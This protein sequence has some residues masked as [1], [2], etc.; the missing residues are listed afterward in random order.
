MASCCADLG[1]EVRIHLLHGV[2]EKH[3]TDL[4]THRLCVSK[5]SFVR[6]LQSGIRYRRLEEL[7]SG[8]DTGS[9]NVLTIDDSTL[10]G[11]E[12]CRIARELGQEVAFFVNPEPVITEMPYF[13]SL[14]DAI[15]DQRTRSFADFEGNR[16]CLQS[17]SEVR[18]WWNLLRNRL[19]YLDPQS[20]LATIRGIGI[21]LGCEL[22][23]IPFHLRPPSQSD[24]RDLIDAGVQVE[25]H[26]WS[27]RDISAM[28]YAS[29]RDHVD[30]G[31]MWIR[32][33]LGVG[34][35]WYA[36]PFGVSPVPEEW[37]S[38]LVRPYLLAS[39]DRDEGVQACGAINRRDISHSLRG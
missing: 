38:L 8:H 31:R 27:H 37:Q 28:D 13:F 4:R 26:G 21:Q 11:V 17:P 16:I 6:H 23:S 39:R 10:A 2:V 35:D 15:I 9:M 7:L 34:A 20:S 19:K 3:D 30:R 12:A 22:E 33:A 25:N 5:D 29:F 18:Q 1:G 32:S 14:F 24:L 36:T